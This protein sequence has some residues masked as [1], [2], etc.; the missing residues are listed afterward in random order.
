[1]V[2]KFIIMKLCLIDLHV[3]FP[4]LRKKVEW[5]VDNAFFV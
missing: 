3:K 1:M 4:F 2:D 5:R